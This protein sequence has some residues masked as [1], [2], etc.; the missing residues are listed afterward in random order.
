MKYQQCVNCIFSNWYPNFKDVTL[1]SKI[2][3][4]SPEFVTYLKSDGIV[5]PDDEKIKYSNTLERYSDDDDDDWGS[6]ANRSRPAMFPHLKVQVEN[7]IR[8]LGGNVSLNLTGV[9]RVT[10]R[11]FLTTV[12]SNVQLSTK[13]VFY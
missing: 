13:Y 4:L 5:L 11:G 9:H 8:Q 1:K 12:P 3:K 7:A 2:I 6:E 10:L